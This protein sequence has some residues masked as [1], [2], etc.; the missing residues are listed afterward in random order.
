MQQQQQR[1][2]PKLIG[3]G[4]S[5]HFTFFKEIQSPEKGRLRKPKY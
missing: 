1:L 5:L 4:Y 3:V 2:N